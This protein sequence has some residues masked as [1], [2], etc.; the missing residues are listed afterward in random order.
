VD[1]TRKYVYMG[2]ERH[3]SSRWQNLGYPQRA[4]RSSDYLLIW[5]I[6]SERW[7]AGAPQAM[8]KE[9]EKLQGESSL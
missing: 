4:V 6:K 1:E 3:F 2:R 8:D 9:T 5:N 7:P